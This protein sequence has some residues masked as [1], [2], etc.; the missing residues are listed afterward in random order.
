MILI[1]QI[2]LN[3]VNKTAFKLD[4][5]FKTLFYTEFCIVIILNEEFVILN[6]SGY[7][8]YRFHMYLG[9]G[10]KCEYELDS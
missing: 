3:L 7:W 1:F 9:V 8:R 4:P 10:V 2:Q 5:K 6:I